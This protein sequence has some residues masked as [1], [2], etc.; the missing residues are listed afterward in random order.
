[1]I[2]EA[3]TPLVKRLVFM[4]LLLGRFRYLSKHAE[5][6]MSY[7]QM[8]ELL[9]P[10]FLS[11]FAVIVLPLLLVAFNSKTTKRRKS[12]TTLK[13]KQEYCRIMFGR[14]KIVRK[15]P[16]YYDGQKAIL[17]YIF[18]IFMISPAFLYYN[19]HVFLVYFV[20]AVLFGTI[21]TVKPVFS[22]EHRTGRILNRFINSDAYLNTLRY[23]AFCTYILLCAVV[24]V[25]EPKR[26]P[27]EFIFV[28]IIGM[29]VQLARGKSVISF[30]LW[31][32]NKGVIA[33]DAQAGAGVIAADAEVDKGALAADAKADKGTIVADP[34]SRT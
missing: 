28:I 2:A 3:A 32:A 11:I 34:D 1:V 10:V 8:G 17:V 4:L 12:R 24:I 5:P 30:F 13:V 9:L 27:L 31:E 26:I 29:R 7:A 23:I 20:V 33:I 19:W 21:C 14:K 16:Q 22:D 6:G 25:L 15:W 18:F